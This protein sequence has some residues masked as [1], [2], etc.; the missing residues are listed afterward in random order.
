[1]YIFGKDSFQNRKEVKFEGSD[2][3]IMRNEYLFSR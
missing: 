1:M 3:W 2:K